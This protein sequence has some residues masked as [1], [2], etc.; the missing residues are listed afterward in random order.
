MVPGNSWREEQLKKTRDEREY[1][2]SNCTRKLVL[3]VT[4]KPE[5][6]NMRYQNHQFI[7]KIFRFLQKKLGITEGYSTFS[8]EA[9]AILL[10]L[11]ETRRIQ[12]PD[13]LHANAQ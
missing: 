3:G 13:H 11:Q 1:P 2:D 4:S 7:T 9:D 8:M 5:F 6:Q 12:G 10:R